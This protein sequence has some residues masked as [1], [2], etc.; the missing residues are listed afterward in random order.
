[1]KSRTR[2]IP[3]V[4]IAA[5]LM[6][7]IFII[8]VFS[9]T[10]A[11]KFID[12]TDPS[13]DLTWARQ[14][15]NVGLQVTDSDLDVAVKRVLL[16][17]DYTTNTATAATTKGSSSVTLSTTTTMSATPSTTTTLIAKDDTV[18]IGNETVRKVVSASTTAGT[19]V[20]N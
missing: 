1:M 6:S 11:V 3:L 10:G 13:K 16:P 4:V 5:V 15:G 2:L 12:S 8:P 18:L 14:G 20:L 19:I 17:A 9:A 7:L